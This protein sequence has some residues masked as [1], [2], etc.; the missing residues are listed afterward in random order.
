M[1]VDDSP[2]GVD[3]GLLSGRF[4]ITLPKKAVLPS[5]LSIGAVATFSPGNIVPGFSAARAFARNS[6]A[7]FALAADAIAFLARVVYE[8]IDKLLVDG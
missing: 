4:A 6:Y 1:F 8:R 5:A 2:D 7:E 3:S